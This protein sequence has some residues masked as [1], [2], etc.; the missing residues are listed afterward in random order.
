MLLCR[1]REEELVVL[2]LRGGTALGREHANDFEPNQEL[3]LAGL[4]LLADAVSV[5]EELVGEGAA[6]DDNARA[7]LDVGIADEGTIGDGGVQDAGVLGC[8]SDRA[9]EGIVTTRDH[10]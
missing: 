10:L 2:T 8:D 9:C 3:P 5:G 4:D 1:K 6:Q 7:A